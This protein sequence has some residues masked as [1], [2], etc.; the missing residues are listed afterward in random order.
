MKG[1]TLRFPGHIEKIAVLRETGL[2]DA[3][4]IEIKGVRIRPL[5]AKLL[6]PR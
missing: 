3:Q 1:K 2:F 5:T 6:F 4:E